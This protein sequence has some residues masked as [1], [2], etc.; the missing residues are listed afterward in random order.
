[1]NAHI[2]G[3][4]HEVRL[5]LVCILLLTK[6]EN[7]RLVCECRA[8]PIIDRQCSVVGNVLGGMEEPPRVSSR[9]AERGRAIVGD[10]AVVRDAS[11]YVLRD[12]ANVSCV[13]IFVLNVEP[14]A[15]ACE[16]QQHNNPA[17]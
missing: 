2:V 15:C 13:S 16:E 6:E 10:E 4:Q 14:W 11:W 1:M 8:V 17:P 12:H 9:T 3:D 7:W 5:L